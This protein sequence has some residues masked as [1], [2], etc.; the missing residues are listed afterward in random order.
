[1]AAPE[2]PQSQRMWEVCER[3][4]GQAL[5]SL[6][7]ALAEPTTILG[8]GMVLVLAVLILVP[9]YE[10]LAETFTTDTG[11]FSLEH[12]QRVMT[13]QHM[14][15]RPLA[16]TLRVASVVTLLSLA[17]GSAL[18][19]LVV[20]S[21]IPW[22][23]LTGKLCVFPFM[24]PSW[25]SGVAWIS[26][27]RNSSH[28]GGRQGL[29][30]SVFGIAMPPWMT[31]GYVPI[32]INLALHYFPFTYILV[33]NALRSL[34]S[35]LEEAAQMLGAGR[36]YVLRRITG[37]I[38]LPAIVSALILTFTMAVGSFGVAAI[39]GPPAR[40]YVL[41]T[42][43]YSL[44]RNRFLSEA[45]VVGVVVTLIGLITIYLN[46]MVMRSR[47]SYATISGKGFRRKRVALGKL[48]PLAIGFVL[49][50]VAMAAF[51]PVGVL[52][53]DSFSSAPG[54][55]T[56]D[57]LTTH[58]WIGDSRPDLGVVPEAEQ[59]I[60][61]NPAML[62]GIWNSLRLAV[63]AG[64]IS[65]FAGIVIGYIV[66]KKRGSLVS[67]ALEFLAFSPYLLPKIPFALA[68]LV[69]F[70][71][72][73]GP[74]PALYGTMIL[75]IVICTVNRL[76]FSSRSGISGMIQVSGELEEAGLVLGA[77][78]L[79]RFRRIMIPLLRPGFAA[80]FVLAFISTMRELDLI[81]ILATPRTTPLTWLV[82]EYNDL[83]VPQLASALA[84]TIVL[85]TFAVYIPAQRML[86][87]NFLSG[88]N[89]E[90]S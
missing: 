36:W 7:Q 37:P 58:F 23:S 87:S 89:Q 3:A 56:I 54:V 51:I 50:V 66:V 86:G 29:L 78:W 16:N 40:F 82:F 64:L 42:I 2:R 28:F 79:Y 84:L 10:M 4:T 35:S 76:P 18:A 63:P 74:I 5:R 33:S 31:Y 13:R 20:R 60:L 67:K 9:V 68:Y 88:A 59:G 65:A 80:G 75:L 19:W 44:V 85:L 69:M 14:L 46:V 6:R 61:R 15:Y 43:T 30:E 81:I 73:R 90:G 48:K 71:H 39:L 24:I 26:V 41:S 25:V 83:D 1:M 47:K 45:Y 21:D 32:V 17:I 38:A 62:R 27:F 34:D 53:W 49:V 8:I 77:R 22:K 12:W 11:R 57:N 72:P 52:T 55:Y 70:A